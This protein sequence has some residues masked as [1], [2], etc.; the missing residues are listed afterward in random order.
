MDAVGLESVD[1]M[2]FIGFELLDLKSDDQ[3]TGMNRRDCTAFTT[4]M[5]K[6]RKELV[7]GSNLTKIYSK[8][9]EE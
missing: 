8:I 7:L 9:N 1:E 2:D 5:T 4:K 3:V 6:D